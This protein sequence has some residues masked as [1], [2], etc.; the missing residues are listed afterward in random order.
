MDNKQYND[1]L[2]NNYNQKVPHFEKNIEA[3]IRFLDDYSI[4][5]K[6]YSH[7]FI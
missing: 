1:Y 4:Y 2:K 6:V 7:P 5:I 3:V